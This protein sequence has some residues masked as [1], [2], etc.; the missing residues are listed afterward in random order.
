MPSSDIYADD[1]GAFVPGQRAILPPTG[2]GSLDGLTFAVKDLIDVAGV[3]TGGGNPDWL[4]SQAIA[5]NSA[6]V[7]RA[8]LSAGAT[9]RGKTITDELAFSL[10]G[11]NAHYGTPIN[12]G[13]PRS[14]SGRLVERIGR[15]RCRRT[16]RCRAWHRHRRLG[17]RAGQ[18]HRC[19]WFPP[20]AW[21]DFVKWRRPVRAILRHHRMVRE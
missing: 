11:V 20:Y 17:A 16:T 10:E 3:R 13:V 21:R 2:S 7:V 4:A 5:A 8:L 1:F 6:P 14:H 9:L 15:R 19:V 18:F 12:P